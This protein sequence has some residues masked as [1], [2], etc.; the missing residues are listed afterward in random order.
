MPDLF[1][2][3]P[4]DPFLTNNY[5]SL[6]SQ[7]VNHQTSDDYIFELHGGHETGNPIYIRM[8]DGTDHDKSTSLV[9]KF[10]TLNF[11]TVEFVNENRL[12]NDK[13]NTLGIKLSATKFEILR[14]FCIANFT[15]FK[16]LAAAYYVKRE[17]TKTTKT[18][19]KSKKKVA[20][21]KNASRRR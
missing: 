15:F 10:D 20:V 16:N 9:T 5:S 4:T 13:M 14:Q 19:P 11:T 1:R 2:C 3:E 6:T 8:S 21:N 18:L 12:K 17:P 7:I